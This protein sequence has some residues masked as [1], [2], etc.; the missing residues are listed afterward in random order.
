M[1]APKKPKYVP[2]DQHVI[3]LSAKQAAKHLGVS[4]TTFYRWT[5]MPDPPPQVLIRGRV[6][7]PWYPLLTW[8]EAHT[9]VDTSKHP[10]TV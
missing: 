2:T 8:I 9:V 4:P 1:K 7:Y 10:A 5:A 3:L 6:Y